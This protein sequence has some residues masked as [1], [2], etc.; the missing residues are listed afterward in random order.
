VANLHLDESVFSLHGNHTELR[1]YVGIFLTGLAFGYAI[2][3]PPLAA[4]LRRP[5]V[6]RTLGALGIA[7]LAGLFLSARDIVGAIPDTVPLIGNLRGPLGWSHPGTFGVACG[8]L[9]A[10]AVTCE[11]S[12]V[13][14]L[15]ACLPLRA[16]GVVSFSLYLAHVLIRDVFIERV[17]WGWPLFTVTLLLSYI[18]ACASY[19]WVE[20]PFMRLGLPSR[21]AAAEDPARPA[22]GG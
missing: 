21:D 11:R 9:I 14:R 6:A 2:R 8:A 5:P 10:I 12:L 19:S 17:D 18:V 7:L 4:A 16:L 22:V 3:W 20:R 13:A 1:W 15:L